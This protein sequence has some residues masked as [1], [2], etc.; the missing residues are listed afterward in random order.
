MPAGEWVVP[1]HKTGR[2][3]DTRKARAIMR[4]M[5]RDVVGEYATTP[6]EGQRVYDVIAPVLA[7]GEQVELDF[8]GIRRCA[9]PFCSFGIGRLI[10]DHTPEQLNEL[11]HVENLG[12]PGADIL[13]L[14]IENADRYYRRPGY[15][16]AMDRA[17]AKM[18]PREE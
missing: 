13:A 3:E 10:Q 6:E 7:K 9:A 4:I 15:R 12:P 18:L 5:V 14:A 1:A 17:W 8:E 16:E 2:L 11:L